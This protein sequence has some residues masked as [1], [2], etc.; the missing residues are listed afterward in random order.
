MQG[1][2]QAQ[3]DQTTELLFL[4]KQGALDLWENTNPPSLIKPLLYRHPH[5]CLYLSQSDSRL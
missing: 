5:K 2:Y 3:P 4:V 1:D